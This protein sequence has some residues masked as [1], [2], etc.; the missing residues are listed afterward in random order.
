MSQAGLKGDGMTEQVPGGRQS[1]ADGGSP[2]VPPKPSYPPT[3]HHKPWKLKFQALNGR[4][5][6]WLFGGVGALVLVLVAGLLTVAGLAGSDETRTAKQNLEPFK[7]ATDDL[8]D[9]PGL[10]YRD[11]S[12]AGITENEITATNGGSQFGTTSSGGRD[13]E[14]DRGVLRIGGKT[15]MRWQVDPAPEETDAKTPSEWMTGLDDGSELVDEALS[16]T[17]PPQKLSTVLSKALA[18][19]EKT[20]PPSNSAQQRNPT[21]DGKPALGADTSAGRLLVTKKKPHRVL[22]LEPYKLSETIDRLQDEEAPA[23]VPKV[24]TG[25]LAGGDG[26]GMDLTPI[27]A[28]AAGAMFDTLLEYTEQLKDA[29][30]NG[31]NFT[32]DGSGDVSCSSSGC[33]VDQKFTGEVSAK[34]REDRVTDGE[35]S[36]V[37]SATFSVGGR[38]AGKCTSSPSTFRVDGKSV[39]GNLT[40]SNPGAGAVY[41]SVAAKAKAEADA[42]SRAS[43]GRSVRYTIPFRADTLVD[44]RALA[45]VEVKQLVDHAKK[46]R[47]RAKCLNPPKSNSATHALF[48]G[49]T[50]RTT[51]AFR[52]GYAP[53]VADPERGL[54]VGLSRRYE[55][56]PARYVSPDPDRPKCEILKF[57]PIAKHGKE[58][59]RNAA[60]E[61]AKP[62]ESLQKSIVFSPNTTRRVSANPDTGEFSVFDES[63]NGTG[64]YH[65]HTRSWAELSQPMQS[66]LRKGGMVNKKG[67]IQSWEE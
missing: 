41:S 17:L 8:A 54:N 64:I 67:K 65:G 61:P 9:A 20:P 30:D 25:P 35:V 10:R 6:L 60:P 45:K 13:K 19:L 51:G 21:V 27:D 26:E 55:A 58:Q 40:C 53:A 57:E 32:I 48:S 24:T 43:G 15:F 18:E 33:S 11:T 2:S 46:E 42:K 36:A 59:R 63:H 7:S 38:P 12:A 22:R 50:G 34:A 66:A 23:E 37:L 4:Q 29:S 44:A 49:G 56:V 1:A 28:D 14:H 62:Q 39:N 3:P 16:R 5:R 52:G 31:I 47:D